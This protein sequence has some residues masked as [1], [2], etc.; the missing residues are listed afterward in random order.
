MNTF[1]RAS[2]RG[3]AAELAQLLG[4]GTSLNEQL[5]LTTPPRAALQRD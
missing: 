3:T 5:H 4:W 1:S 2:P